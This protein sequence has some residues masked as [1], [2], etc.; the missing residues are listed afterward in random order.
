[1]K[2]LICAQEAPLGPVN[3]FRRHLH[4]AVQALGAAHNVRVLALRS[5]EQLPREDCRVRLVPRP[6]PEV[7]PAWD[8]PAS[9]DEFSRRLRPA[10]RE[11]LVQFAPDFVYVTGVC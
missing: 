7:L 3:G 9:Y 4:A 1:M 2:V 5:A 11:E 10:L 8:A 6:P